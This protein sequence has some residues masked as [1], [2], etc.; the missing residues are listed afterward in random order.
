MMM[1]NIIFFVLIPFFC[2]ANYEEFFLQANAAYQQKEYKQ[3]LHLYE[4][5]E[6]KSG[7][8]LYNMG[9]CWYRIGDYVSA[10]IYWRKAEN[11]GCVGLPIEH[12]CQ[13]AAEKL[14]IE[15][16][17]KNKILN[18]CENWVQSYSIGLWQFLFLLSWYI[19]LF[20][21]CWVRSL[22]K[23]IWLLFLLLPQG[24]ISSGLTLKVFLLSKERGI[25]KNEEALLFVGTDEQ[26][27]KRGKIARGQEVVIHEKRGAWC[28]VSRDHQSGWLKTD[29]LEYVSC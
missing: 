25:I 18:A 23:K 3:A 6:P 12:N 19:L 5:I 28:K 22:R 20:G 8:V 13:K 14:R 29:A 2:S 1:L 27:S 11:R 16:T 10:L 17:H 15:A 4:K 26:F 21:L 7:I 9:N 24:V